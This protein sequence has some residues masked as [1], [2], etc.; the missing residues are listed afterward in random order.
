MIYCVESNTA[1]GK[2]GSYIHTQSSPNI[3][4]RL[5][6]AEVSARKYQRVKKKVGHVEFVQIKLSAF[7]QRK[8]NHFILLFS[9]FPD[10]H[11]LYDMA[12]WI[13]YWGLE[14]IKSFPCSSSEW[15]LWPQL[16]TRVWPGWAWLGGVRQT[17]L[18]VGARI[19]PQTVNTGD[20]GTGHNI[21]LTT[22]PH[23]RQ[24]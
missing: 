22:P 24:S 8:D 19:G 3:T 7:L 4:S 10:L 15:N 23:T 1:S 12:H 16:L 18:G 17:G 9:I 21:A 20:L 11:Q 2:S 6:S 13:D 5:Y 14:A